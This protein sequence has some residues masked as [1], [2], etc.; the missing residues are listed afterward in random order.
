MRIAVLSS[1]YRAH[2]ENKV[3]KWKTKITTL[4]EHLQNLIE[5]LDRQTQYPQHTCMTAHCPMTLD[6]VS[7]V[8]TM[9]GWHCSASP[10]HSYCNSWQSWSNN[11]CGGWWTRLS[12]SSQRCYIWF[13]SGDFEDHGNTL[14]LFWVRK[15]T[16]II[17]IWGRASSTNKSN[18][19]DITE[20]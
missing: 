15:S 13:Q 10:W 20:I 2:V 5:N 4:S 12:S 1:L 18:R 3:M 14:M 17:A 16:V 19:H 9:C 7:I 11:S 6:S 8:T